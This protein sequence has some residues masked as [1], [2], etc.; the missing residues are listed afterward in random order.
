[1]KFLAIAL[2]LLLPLSAG[3]EQSAPLK[4]KVRFKDEKKRHQVDLEAVLKIDESARRLAVQS[5]EQPWEL[6]YDDVRR[7]II[8]P[9][10]H[11]GNIGFGAALA[12]FAAGGLLFGGKIATAIDNPLKA[13]H[14][15]YVEPR[16]NAKGLPRVLVVAKDSAPEALKRI[17]RAFGDLVVLPEFDE[18][19]EKLDKKEFKSVEPFEVKGSAQEHPLP[20][21][22]PDHGLVVVAAPLGGSFR[23]IETEKT[24]PFYAK[25]LVGNRV[26]A[27]NAPGS[28]SFFHLEPGEH[29]LVSQA[30]VDKKLVDVTGLRL[31]V[32]AGKEYHLTQTIYIGGGMKSFLARHSKEVVMQEVNDLRLAEWKPKRR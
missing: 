30:M 1:M 2:A 17:K 3:A 25:V 16:E 20:V 27:A 4:I 13:D 7:I 28:Y 26:L 14:V 6:G 5:K 9:D 29:L 19:P 21:A 12:G 8:E 10:S 23:P 11:A 18:Q 32:E 22:R 31:K 24:T 15:V